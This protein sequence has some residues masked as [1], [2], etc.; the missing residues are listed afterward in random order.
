MCKEHAK[1]ASSGILKPERG[2]PIHPCSI[3]A[4]K[5]NGCSRI[6]KGQ[7]EELPIISVRK[8]VL[9]HRTSRRQWLF[10]R[11]TQKPAFYLILNLTLSPRNIGRERLMNEFIYDTKDTLHKL[12]TEK[13]V[14]RGCLHFL[15]NVHIDGGSLWFIFIV[16]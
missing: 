5:N 4:R 13:K 10:L 3:F 11:E 15:K 6:P 2:H 8:Q 1:H 14:Q 16:L 7:P 9:Y 12:S